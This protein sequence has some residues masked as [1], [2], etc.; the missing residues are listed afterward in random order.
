M[1]RRWAGLA[2]GCLWLLA[3]TAG[4]VVQVGDKADLSFTDNGTNL[5]YKMSDFAGKLV[6]LDFWALWSPASTDQI[7][8]I[9]QLNRQYA[10][11]G[12]QIITFNMDVD[13][14]VPDAAKFAADKG[15]SWPQGAMGA[16][17]VGRHFGADK[18]PYTVLIGPDG[19]VLWKGDP[20]T[21]L[22]NAVTLAYREHPPFEDNLNMLRDATAALDALEKSLQQNDWAAAARQLANIPPGVALDKQATA[23]LAA[24]HD[25]LEQAGNQLLAEAEQVIQLH[26]Y[27]AAMEKLKA[28]AGQFAGFPAASKAHKRLAEV[29]AVSAG[30][31]PQAEVGLKTTGAEAALAAARKLQAG[32]QD[33]E[34]YARFKMISAA[35][36]GS[37][38]A[39]TAAQEVAAYE[40]NAELMKRVNDAAAQAKAK[41]ALGMAAAY[42]DAG[43]IESARDKYQEVIDQFPNTPWAQTAREQ[44]RHLP[45]P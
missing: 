30:P 35:Y 34:A 6:L 38:E 44:L 26:Q 18:I 40:Q 1:R 28:I 36:P 16:Q 14:A 32:G 8:Y 4:A 31:R 11:K 5:S 13:R 43:Q 27:Q 41:S 37:R 42:K 2:A 33:V 9:M 21:G 15:F 7:T 20:A 22:D 12:L 45:G 17:T 23:R 24:D 19:T 29:A 10:K 39:D 3:T 25:A